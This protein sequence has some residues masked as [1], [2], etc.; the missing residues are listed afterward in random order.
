MGVGG[1]GRQGVQICPHQFFRPLNFPPPGTQT[2]FYPLTPPPPGVGCLLYKAIS[3]IARQ[4]IPKVVVPASIVALHAAQ[5]RKPNSV[6]RKKCRKSP[7]WSLHMAVLGHVE[8]IGGHDLPTDA[9][10]PSRRTLPRA[11][12]TRCG[13]WAATDRKRVGGLEPSKLSAQQVSPKWRKR[14]VTRHHQP[15]ACGG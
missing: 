5:P 1:V 9:D 6:K 3:L 4:H 8:G 14:R 15:H 11:G 13:M 7:L 12:S 2:F 10:T